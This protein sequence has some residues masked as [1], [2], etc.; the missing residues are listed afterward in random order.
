MKDQEKKTYVKPDIRVISEEE[1]L[2]AFQVS[3][4]LSGWWVQ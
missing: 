2:V 4:C 1:M 3:A